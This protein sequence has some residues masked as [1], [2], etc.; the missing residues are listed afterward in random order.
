MID[1]ETLTSYHWG[2]SKVWF[3]AAGNPAERMGNGAGPPKVTALVT[4]IFAAPSRIAEPTIRAAKVVRLA[5]AAAE[6]ASSRDYRSLQPNDC[7]TVLF[8]HM[9]YMPDALDLVVPCL[10][11]RG[12]ISL[13][14]FI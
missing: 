14:S 10:F 5:A 8:P 6:C 9:R 11:S 12:Y 2:Y 4:G 1:Q 7:L 13:R 3:E